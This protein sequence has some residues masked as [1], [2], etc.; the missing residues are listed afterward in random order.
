M[1]SKDLRAPAYG[2]VL[3]KLSGEALS[4]R[5]RHGLHEGTLRRIAG[6][7][8]DVLALGVETAIV[9]GGGNI[10]RG[11]HAQEL[12][13][14]RISGDHMGMLA[15]VINALAFRDVMEKQGIA[16]RVLTAFEL[17]AMAETYS[18]SRAAHHLARRRAVIFAGGT[19][20]PFFSTDTAAA[21]RALE[22]GAEVILKAT[23]VDGVYDSDPVKKRAA[24]KF[25]RISYQEVL[26]RRLKF[27]DATAVSLCMDNALPIVVFNL[28]GKGN[29][30]RVVCAEALGTVIS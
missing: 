17:P 7:V 21:L 11:L 5:Q 8:G 10:C 27:M 6:E 1:S 9:V 13:V 12:G 25:D 14:D 19:G 30:R 16:A 23:K 28:K 2:R 20:N 24:K 26:K 29:V 22:V 15:T 18:P 3:L 4:G